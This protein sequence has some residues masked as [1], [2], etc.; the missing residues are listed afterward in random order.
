M[1][2]S[3]PGRKG[4]SR[5]LA[6]RSVERTMERRRATYEEEVRRLVSASFELVRRDGSLEPRVGEIVAEAGLSNQAFYKHFRSKDELLLAV[7]DEGIRILRT[8]LEH[9]MLKVD[10]PESK[11]RRCC[12]LP[13]PSSRPFVKGP[14]IV[15]APRPST[16]TR[17][18]TKSAG[19][20]AA[21]SATR[22]APKPPPG[23]HACTST[24]T[25][26]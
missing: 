13:I 24:P 22:R 14:T 25:V 20:I 4:E 21:A 3:S 9:Q 11:A 10:T 5:P 1:P 8:Y 15:A 6:L 18:P 26:S 17:R 23:R 12:D 16:R 2:A 7:L 19:G